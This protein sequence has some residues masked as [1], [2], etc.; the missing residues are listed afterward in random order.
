M[1]SFISN[2]N[3]KT[4][5]KVRFRMNRDSEWHMSSDLNELDKP[6]V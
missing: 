1:S 4:K 3:V 5:N 6:A 2:E